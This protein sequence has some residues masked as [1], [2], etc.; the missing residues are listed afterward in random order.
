MRGGK[1]TPLF[2][3]QGSRVNDVHIHLGNSKLEWREKWVGNETDLGLKP[4][5]VTLDESL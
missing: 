5:S 1:I 2:P 4:G 3:Q